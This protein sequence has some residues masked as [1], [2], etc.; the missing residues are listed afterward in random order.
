MDNKRLGTFDKRVDELAGQIPD[1]IRGSMKPMQHTGTL[2]AIDTM[3]LMGPCADYLFH[4]LFDPARVSALLALLAMLRKVRDAGADYTDPNA[5]L[6]CRALRTDVAAGLAK[7]EKDFPPVV[8]ALIVHLIVHI[9]DCIYRWNSVRN[10]WAFATERYV[11][12]RSSGG[13][14]CVCWKLG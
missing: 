1:W 3:R 7:F 2:K 4:G 9:P 13:P 5:L 11:E 10:W 6:S 14:R 8:H 12:W